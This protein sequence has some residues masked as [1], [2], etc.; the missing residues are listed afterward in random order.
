MRSTDRLQ[1]VQQSHPIA[2]LAALQPG[3]TQEWCDYR[4]H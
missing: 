3:K 2:H 4:H 1:L